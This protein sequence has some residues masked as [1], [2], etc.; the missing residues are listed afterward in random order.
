MILKK[1]SLLKAFCL[2][3]ALLHLLSGLLGLLKRKVPLKTILP[4]VAK[5]AKVAKKGKL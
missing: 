1:I 4:V 3:S 5:A 2:L